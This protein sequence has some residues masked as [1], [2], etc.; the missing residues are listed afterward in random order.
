MVCKNSCFYFHKGTR[1]HNIYKTFDQHQTDCGMSKTKNSCIWES[2]HCVFALDCEECSR[3][4]K[5]FIAQFY[6]FTDLCT[7]GFVC[8]F[9]QFYHRPHKSAY[10]AISSDDYELITLLRSVQIALIIECKSWL[11]NNKLSH[12]TVAWCAPTCL[13]WTLKHQPTRTGSNFSPGVRVQKDLA[14]SSKQRLVFGCFLLV[15]LS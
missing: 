3:V 5:T 6:L 15:V 10:N 11:L 13:F 1:E 7:L 8:S 2:V 4:Q 14:S 12:K 9:W